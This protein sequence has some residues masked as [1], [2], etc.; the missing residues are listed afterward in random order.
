MSQSRDIKIS[1]Y[2]NSVEVPTK[3]PAKKY[4][5]IVKLPSEADIED[6]ASKY[7]NGIL[8]I[9]SNKKSKG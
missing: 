6:T 3:D 8:E 1:A 2:D 9:T 4:H 7:T 5:R